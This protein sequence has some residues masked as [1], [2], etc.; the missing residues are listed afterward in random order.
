[1]NTDRKRYVDSAV[2]KL[3]EIAILEDVKEILPGIATSFSLSGNREIR[4]IGKK[5]EELLN[6]T[7]QKKR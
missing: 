1:M 7:K 3:V 5:L 6:E 2:K 4:D